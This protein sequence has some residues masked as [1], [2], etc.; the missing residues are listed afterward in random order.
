MEFVTC[1]VSADDDEASAIA[2]SGS[3]LEDWSGIEAPGVDTIKLAA[4][5]SLLTGDSL[6]RA[7]DL[8]EPIAADEGD[9]ETIVLRIDGELF[10]ALAQLDEEAIENLVDELAATE[11]YENEAYES[12]DIA[13]YLIAL[14]DLAQLAES[15]AQG[16]F[17]WIRLL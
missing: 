1:I 10:D 16:L 7:L 11:A 13:S 3:P 4:L 8:Y 5:H 9:N 2:A 6:Q 17:V 12:D 14:A 15:Q